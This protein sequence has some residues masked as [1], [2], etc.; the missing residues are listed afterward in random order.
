MA[1]KPVRIVLAANARPN[2]GGQGVNLAQF[3]EALH[4]EF[5][6]TMF[7]RAPYPGVPS[8]TVP[9]SRRAKLMDRIPVVRGLHNHRDHLSNAHFDRCVAERMPAADLFQGVTG[10]CLCSLRRAKE[11]G[12][13][14]ILDCITTHVDDY[15]EKRR[16]ESVKAGVRPAPSMAAREMALAEYAAAERIRVM[17]DYAKRTMVDHGVPERQVF[18]ARPPLAMEGFPVADFSAPRFRVSYV[19]MLVPA[20]GYRYLIDAFRSFEEPDSEMIFW[21]APGNSVINRYMQ[22]QMTLDPR[23]RMQ[24]VSVRDNYGQVYGKSHV[25]VQPSLADGYSY[26]VMEAMASGLPVIVTSSTGSAELIRDG[27]NGYII[28]PC[29]AGAIRE[30]LT[31]LAGHPELLRR[32][33]AAARETI[34]SQN[35]KA[36]SDGYCAQ[37][38]TFISTGVPCSM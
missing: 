17:S 33:G 10:Q 3:I 4:P 9:E 14:T 11:M 12:A 2:V 23:I 28:P 38:R 25:V 20:K 32:M 13:F 18:V 34:R 16:E 31:H 7:G 19:G 6:V 29:D 36:F 15:F 22:R 5:Q 35:P 1:H 26:A 30:R 21:T 27:E 37:I 24:P 8:D